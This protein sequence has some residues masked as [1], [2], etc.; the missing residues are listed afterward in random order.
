[1]IIFKIKTRSG[2]LG[3]VSQAFAAC[4][5]F[6]FYLR[7]PPLLE[8]YVIDCF[9]VQ[10]TA[11][12]Q[13][14]GKAPREKEKERRKGERAKERR[15]KKRE[16]TSPPIAAATVENSFFLIPLFFLCFLASH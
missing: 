1:M 16:G 10:V 11:Q 3:S 2:F 4:V 13:V 14:R 15:M 12:H 5:S 9:S 8:L 6:L 7:T